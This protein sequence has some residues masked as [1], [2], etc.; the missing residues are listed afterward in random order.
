MGSVSVRAWGIVLLLLVVF[1]AVPVSVGHIH[2][3][4]G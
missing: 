4:G 3:P 2:V 1:P